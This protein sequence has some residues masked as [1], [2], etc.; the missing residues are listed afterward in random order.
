VHELSCDQLKTTK[1]MLDIT[2][3]HASSKEAVRAIFSQG[4]RKVAPNGGQGV[5]LK[6]VGKGVKRRTKGIKMGPKR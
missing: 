6:A 3:R 2:T 1:E 5:T 4:D